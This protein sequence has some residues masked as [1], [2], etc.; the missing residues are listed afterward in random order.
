[1]APQIF[2][3]ELPGDW[4]KSNTTIILTSGFLIDFE[5]LKFP[6]KHNFTISDILSIFFLDLNNIS[7]LN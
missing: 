2:S 3:Q 7:I 6:S 1:M 5:L 4:D